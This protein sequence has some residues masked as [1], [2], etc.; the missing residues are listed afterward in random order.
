MFDNTH[1]VGG[2]YLP[3]D[4][5]EALVSGL[6]NGTTYGVSIVGY[7]TSDVSLGSSCCSG[8]M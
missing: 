6:T 4:A 2:E 7:L 3:G 5:S 8:M 1:L